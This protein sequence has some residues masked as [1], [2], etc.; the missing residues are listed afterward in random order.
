MLPM[1][2]RTKTPRLT[3][4]LSAPPPKRM[5]LAPA[6]NPEAAPHTPPPARDPLDRLIAA[7]V[8]NF[9]HATSWEQFFDLQRDP[10]GTLR[11]PARDLLVEHKHDG[12]PVNIALDER[13]SAARKQLN[14]M[15]VPWRG[16]SCVCSL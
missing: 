16:R 10:R 1:P 9:K 11:H 4:T 2:P 15:E 13:W 5:R 7:A 12:V 8:K 3:P 6:L 14:P